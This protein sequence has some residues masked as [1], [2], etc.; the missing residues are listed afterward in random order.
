MKDL[1][2]PAADMTNYARITAEALSVMHW[3]AKID[4]KG[5]EFVLAPPWGEAIRADTISN[6]LDDHCMWLLDFDLCRDITRDKAGVRQAA[7]AFWG[8]DPYYP[9]PVKGSVNMGSVSR[10]ISAV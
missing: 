9:R 2:I 7:Q 10:A 3:V 5:V 6:V 8:N 4:G 1:R